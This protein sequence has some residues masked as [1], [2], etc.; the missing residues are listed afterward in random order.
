MLTRI[1]K[2]TWRRMASTIA[3]AIC[4]ATF[5]PYAANAAFA[6]D[7]NASCAAATVER[8]EPVRMFRCRGRTI[9][10]TQNLRI[11]GLGAGPEAL[12][13]ASE[14]EQLRSALCEKWLGNPSP[15]DWSPKCELLLHATAAAYLK[16]V[17]ADHADTAGASTVELESRRVVAR[18]IDIRADRPGW[19]NGAL[20]HE[21]T[22]LVLADEFAQ[23]ELPLWADEGMAVLADPDAKQQLHL[24]DWQQGRLQGAER[25]LA[26]LFADGGLA[27]R[28]ETPVF[29]GQSLSLV[30]F[31][32]DRKTP[33]DFVRFLHQVRISG[34]EAAIEE[35]YGLR[36]VAELESQWRQSAESLVA[37]R[38]SRG[39][40][41]L[42]QPVRL[43]GSAKRS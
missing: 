15:A 42:L 29:Y 14:C 17:G 9:V 24:R 38:S 35:C 27:N 10:E 34:Y 5:S 4:A 41:Y 33:A 2:F 6:A 20:A 22:H 40:N 43:V 8:Q 3:T 18:R 30:K 16:A 23:G 19:L 25:R 12:R 11:H 36:G 31:L 32:V 39:H 13:W 37:R 28:Q 21:L 1:T 7:H 26:K